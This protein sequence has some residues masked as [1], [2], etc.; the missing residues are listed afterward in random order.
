MTHLPREVPFAKMLSIFDSALSLFPNAPRVSFLAV[1]L[2]LQLSLPFILHFVFSPFDYNWLPVHVINPTGFILHSTSREAPSVGI[3]F[4]PLSSSP[5]KSRGLEM[6][7]QKYNLGLTCAT[8]WEP[9]AD[10]C[11]SMT[12][13]HL[14]IWFV[15][16]FEYNRESTRSA[17]PKFFRLGDDLLPKP[18]Q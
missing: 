3:C 13:S 4:S 1:P 12:F 16:R 18:L 8:S 2:F 14:Y 9:K 5:C 15:P 7:F 17:F 11:I 6:Y 10:S